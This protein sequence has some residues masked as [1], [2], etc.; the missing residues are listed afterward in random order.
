MSGVFHVE[1]LGGLFGV[2]PLRNL[3]GE[4]WL[5]WFWP[6]ARHGRSRHEFVPRGTLLYHGR[7]LGLNCCWIFRRLV[8]QAQNHDDTK[9]DGK[10]DLGDAIVEDLLVGV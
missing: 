4:L 8:A 6:I 2:G 10:E 1:H 7:K 9:E 3:L 5:D